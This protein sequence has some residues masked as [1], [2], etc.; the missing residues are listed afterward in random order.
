M[1][2]AS[3]TFE[4]CA[5]HILTPNCSFS[6]FTPVCEGL[7][8]DSPFIAVEE[9]GAR[10]I[11]SVRSCILMYRRGVKICRSM[12]WLVFTKIIDL[13]EKMFGWCNSDAEDRISY[14]IT[15][16][17]MAISGK[18]SLHSSHKNSRFFSDFLEKEV[19]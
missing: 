9:S 4:I 19:S 6:L 15:L 18:M 16:S 5:K 3:V 10:C 7:F 11:K 8:Q 13:N 14:P 2:Q 12:Y 17:L 1:C